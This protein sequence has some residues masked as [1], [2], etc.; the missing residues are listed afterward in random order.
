M[1]GY[2]KHLNRISELEKENRKLRN[3]L[4]DANDVIASVNSAI[5]A[6]TPVIDFDALDV[7]SIERLVDNN[8]PTTVIGH[9]VYNPVVNDNGEFV[10][11]ETK[12]KQWYLFCNNERH[13]ELVKQFKEWKAKQNG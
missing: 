13:E 7:F 1:F 4:K 6:A 9:Y 3:E 2:A 12:I 11:Q 10:A 8:R 5:T